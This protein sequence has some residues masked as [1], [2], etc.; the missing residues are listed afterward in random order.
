MPASCVQCFVTILSALSAVEGLNGQSFTQFSSWFDR[1]ATNGSHI[2]FYA[3]PILSRR[4]DN[5]YAFV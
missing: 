5:V 1:L 4:I 3:P 2:N